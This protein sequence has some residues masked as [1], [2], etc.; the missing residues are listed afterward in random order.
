MAS[1]STGASCAVACVHATADT[2][3]HSCR[4]APGPIADT[5]GYRRLVPADSKFVTMLSKE[6]P[7][8]RMGAPIRPYVIADLAD[9]LY[10]AGKIEDIANAAIFLASDASS[11][12][13]GHTM[14]VDGGCWFLGNVNA[15]L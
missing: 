1:V 11:Y 8:Q 12:M 7:L 9:A 5:E 3:C 6:M 4:I 14:V 10:C 15:R 13:T 2:D